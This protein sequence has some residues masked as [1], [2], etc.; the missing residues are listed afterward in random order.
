MPGS[1]G[2]VPHLNGFQGM[3][4]KKDAV[5]GCP[6]RFAVSAAS[7]R[8]AGV[9]MMAKSE[10]LCPGRLNLVCYSASAARARVTKLRAR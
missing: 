6:A 10:L 2:L 9:I 8:S 1:R 7:I 5:R 3:P 4:S